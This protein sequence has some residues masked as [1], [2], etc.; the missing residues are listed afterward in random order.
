MIKGAVAIMGRRYTLEALAGKSMSSRSS[1][2]TQTLAGKT[3]L[4]TFSTAQRL[5]NIGPSSM[6]I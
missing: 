6:S 4:Q 5:L 3:H 2:C 1:C